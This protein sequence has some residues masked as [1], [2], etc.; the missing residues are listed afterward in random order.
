MSFSYQRSHLDILHYLQMGYSVH[1]ESLLCWRN[2]SNGL[3]PMPWIQS[4]SSHLCHKVHFN[5][6]L[7]L[8]LHL[9]S[10]LFPHVLRLK[11]W[12]YFTSLPWVLHYLLIPFLWYDHPNNISKNWHSGMWISNEILHRQFHYSMTDLFKVK[13]QI[14]HLIQSVASC[15]HRSV[16]TSTT[17][18]I[19]LTRRLVMVWD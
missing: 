16:N 3:R 7:L 9:P 1:S 10:Y 18:Y 19:A 12:V 5:S 8:C 11:L 6:A 15:P 17:N 14:I 4:T 2:L 13:H